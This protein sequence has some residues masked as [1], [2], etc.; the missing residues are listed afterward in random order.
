MTLENASRGGGDIG[1]AM[2]AA[3]GVRD[4]TRD[5][6]VDRSQVVIYVETLKARDFEA[7]PQFQ[8]IGAPWNGV[9][10]HMRLK[11]GEYE[12]LD[13]IMPHKAGAPKS[14]AK[15]ERL[16]LMVQM[17]GEGRDTKEIVKVVTAA[18]PK[19]KPATVERDIRDFKKARY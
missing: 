14:D 2:S 18:F 6:G 12:P 7:A 9:D 15:A 3:Y 11:P 4:V 5:V 1:A 19:V 16:T 10:L 13:A 17:I 8:V